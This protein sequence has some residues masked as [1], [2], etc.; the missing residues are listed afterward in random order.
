MT[1]IG[2]VEALVLR[3]WGH[4]VRIDAG[5]KDNPEAH[6][7]EL[8]EILMKAREIDAN[9]GRCTY[10]R[11]N[12]ERPDAPRERCVKPAGH[13]GDHEPAS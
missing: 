4:G 11:W 1:D 5:D 10:R 3:A 9:E 7:K 13:K 12:I 6:S 8:L 2:E